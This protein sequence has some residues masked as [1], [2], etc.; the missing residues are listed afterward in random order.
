VQASAEA[1]DLSS[2]DASSSS[3]AQQLQKGE[4]Q[5]Q[6]RQVQDSQGSGSEEVCNI[7]ST[8]ADSQQVVQ[9]QTPLSTGQGSLVDSNADA[10]P[11]HDSSS[12]ADG[13]ALLAAMDGMLAD[14]GKLQLELGGYLQQLSSKADDEGQP[15]VQMSEDYNVLVEQML[16]EGR[17]QQYRAL[18]GWEGPHR[19]DI[20]FT[21]ASC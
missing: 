8:G 3:Q 12:S 4:E 1:A 17:A 9:Q 21:A 20:S 2:K 13:Q 11:T 14:R 10:R 16:R 7:T 15:L 5:L 18:Q 19:F 6:E